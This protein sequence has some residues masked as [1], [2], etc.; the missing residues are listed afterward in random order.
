MVVAFEFTDPGLLTVSRTRNHATA[1]KPMKGDG[2]GQ[3]GRC[4]SPVVGLCGLQSD[5]TVIVPGIPIE[6][7]NAS[8][9]TNDIF[10]AEVGS[11]Q[12]GRKGLRQE[13]TR[14]GVPERLVG[15]ACVKHDALNA[16]G[17]WERRFGRLRRDVEVIADYVHERTAAFAQELGDPG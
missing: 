1:G 17:E 14:L 13:P 12:L 7:L 5:P 11:S 10:S 6:P 15:D 8:G 9:P 2:I 3:T 16:C 4:E